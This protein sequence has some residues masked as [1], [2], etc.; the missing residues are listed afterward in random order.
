MRSQ[1][2]PSVAYIG[3]YTRKESFVDGKGKGIYVF[4][5]DPASGALTFDSMISGMINPSFLA[6]APSKNRLY[7]VNE[8]SGKVG[9][10]GLV[11]AFAIDPVTY[12]LTYLN[13]QSTHGLA[14]CH[15]SIDSTG[16]FVLVANYETGSLCV[17]PVMADGR[18]GKAS[19]VIQLQG[20]GPHPRQEGPHAHMITPGPDGRFVFAVDL[21]TDR[22][23]VYRLEL[24][25]GKLIPADP[26]W[27]QLPPGTGPRHLI[28]HPNRR[29]A[30][31]INE[32]QSSIISFLYDER[33]G[34]LQAIQS[35][36]TVPDDFA[37]ENLSA[38][39]QIAPTGK[40]IYTS[41]RGHDSIVVFAVDGETGE[42]AYIGHEHHRCAS[43]RHF[44]LV[45]S[46]SYLFFANQDGDTV[47]TFQVDPG[48]GRL[49]VTDQEIGVPTPACIQLY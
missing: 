27:T 3:T 28:F 44:T 30:Y 33:I 36:S 5:L 7:A 8:I 21:G 32:L 22:I 19:D 12:D 9:L 24:E 23:Y 43:P 26:P 4:R 18:L 14:P 15:L 25:R 40:F 37:G 31:V 29:F 46:G 38:E 6:I 17:L 48:S 35:I 11:S 41:N 10:H 2:Q 47:V 39:I 49:T 42:L 13:S 34:S 1:P 45:P 16:R 20:S